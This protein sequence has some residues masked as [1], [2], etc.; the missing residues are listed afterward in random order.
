MP[1]PHLY[2]PSPGGL[3]DVAPSSKR[4]RGSRDGHKWDPDAGAEWHAPVAAGPSVAPPVPGIR[5]GL[6][7]REPGPDHENYLTR[8]EQKR[9]WKAEKQGVKYERRRVKRAVRFEKRAAKYERRQR[10]RELKVAR[11][12]EGHTRRDDLWKLLVFFHGPRRETG[13]S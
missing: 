5:E 7:G 8:H 4:E 2:E 3:F 11:R 13:Q 1:V 10:R 12:A 9:A 6:E